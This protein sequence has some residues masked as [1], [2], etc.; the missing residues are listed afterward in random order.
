MKSV[1]E[2]EEHNLVGE[3]SD[4][5]AILESHKNIQDDDAQR[6]AEVVHEPVQSSEALMGTINFDG[7]LHDVKNAVEQFAKE[8][9]ADYW[10][11]TVGDADQFFVASRDQ[12][13]RWVLRLAKG[14][15]TPDDFEW[16]VKGKKDVAEMTLLKQAGVAL[17]RVDEIKGGLLNVIVKTIL[18]KVL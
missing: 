7:I 5:I 15:L 2:V 16:L 4:L 17:I 1:T 10:K 18:G 14:E 8:K 13:E 11:E 9:V 6:S 12:L 3:V